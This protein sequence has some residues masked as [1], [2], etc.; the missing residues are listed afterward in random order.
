MKDIPI[1]EEIFERNYGVLTFKEQEALH[2]ARVT[3]VGVG[4][5]GGIA[6]IQCARMGIGNLH[7]IEGDSFVPS[8]L[9]RQM[10]SFLSNIGKSKAEEAER[11]LKDINPRI[12]IGTTKD[13]ITEENAKSLLS[14][15][16]IILDA[17]DNLVSRVI[18]HRFAR[19]LGILSVWIAVTPPFRGGV[20]CFSPTSMP[21]EEVL[22]YPSPG[23]ELTDEYKKLITLIKDE[24]ARFSVS[25]GALA[26]W[27][28]Q[29]L[30]GKKAWAV[31]S[32]VANIVGLLASFEIMKLIIRRP[33]LNPIYSPQLLLV[34]MA[35]NPLV[36]IQTS[37]EGN[38]DYTKL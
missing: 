4:G 31:V 3:I 26:D 36:S 34:D 10:L 24:R 37:P 23:G 19:K 38:W 33:D 27:C 17:T 18:I 21:Y 11:I 16:D 25:K 12:N 15:A 22:K 14:G 13:F 8:N 29:Y 30:I 35:S 6:A 9:N 28:T 5:V 1:Y 7:I 20:M 2:G 32:P